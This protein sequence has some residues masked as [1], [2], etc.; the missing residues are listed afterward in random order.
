MVVSSSFLGMTPHYCYFLS[1]RDSLPLRM[2]RC[3]RLETIFS[4]IK[5]KR[6]RLNPANKTTNA[7]VKFFSERGESFFV[8][9]P[10][11]GF[12]VHCGGIGRYQ[13]SQKLTR[14]ISCRFN[15]LISLWQRMQQN[16]NNYWKAILS[17]C[18]TS[19]PLLHALRVG[20]VFL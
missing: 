18:C 13:V 20:T 2:R 7:P 12:P 3:S 16:S 19:L 10:L 14:P 6:E 5:A 4:P 8:L 1:L 11:W 17:F 15:T 9:F